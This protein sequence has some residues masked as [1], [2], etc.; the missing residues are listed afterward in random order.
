M[1][2]VM[3]NLKLKVWAALACTALS[4]PN[5]SAQCESWEAFPD[6]VD[7]AKAA[8]TRYR[9]DFKAQ[10]YDAAFKEWEP[11]FQHVKAP[12]EAPERHFLDGAYMLFVLAQKEADATKK[13]EM[14]DRMAKL[15]EDNAKCNGDKSGTNRAYQGYYMFYL[16]SPPNQ[17]VKVFEKAYSLDQHKAH[18][19]IIMPWAQLAVY[20]FQNNDPEY[21]ADKMRFLYQQFKEWT[22]KRGNDGTPQG[23][24]YKKAWEAVEQIFQPIESKIFGC[25]FYTEKYRPIFEKNKMD[26]EQNAKILQELKYKGQCTEDSP[27]YKAIYEVYA[28]WKREKDSL[29]MIANF[30]NLS[31]LQKAAIREKEG[32]TEEAFDYYRKALDDK[33]LSD[34]DKA[35]TAYRIAYYEFNTKKNFAVARSYARKASSFRPNWGEPYILVGLMYASSGKACSNGVG[36]G[37]D[38]QVV[39]WPA[40]DEWQK[41]KSIDPSVADQANKYI[42]TYSQYLPSSDEGFQRGIKAGSSYQVGC[43][44]G[45]TT[46]VRFK[47]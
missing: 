6:G 32:K 21:N 28:P 2:D 34:E 1:L 3:R 43:W 36:T 19:M 22:E 12:K 30:D 38:A 40:F 31:N 23:A 7:R 15:Y 5:L 4:L 18:S 42:G 16:Q 9:D 39:I 46:T 37:W 10:R 14:R 20:L 25:D 45:V 47:D 33:E 41:A 11:L 35:Q 17:T 8:H 26:M 13:A 24:E 44:I 27:L 29:E